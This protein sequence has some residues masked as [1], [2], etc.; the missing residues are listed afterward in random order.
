MVVDYLRY[1]YTADCQFGTDPGLTQRIQWYRCAD[2][3]VPFGFPVRFGSEVWYGHEPFEGAGERPHFPSDWVDGSFPVPVAGNT[4]FCGTKQVMQNGWPGPLPVG[5]E[6]RNTGLAV[7][8]NPGPWNSYVRHFVNS[9]LSSSQIISHDVNAYIA[10]GTIITH[11][12]NATLATGESITHNVDATL[13]TGESITHNVDATLATGESIYHHIESVL[14]ELRSIDHNVDAT[15]ATGESKTH[16]VDATLATGESKTHNVDAT[17]ATGESKTHNVDATLALGRSKTHN[18]DATLALGRSKTHNVDATL[19]LGR[20]KTH[21]VNSFVANSPNAIQFSGSAGSYAIANAAGLP[22]GNVTLTISLWVKFVAVSASVQEVFV[23]GASGAPNQIYAFTGTA[24]SNQWWIGN[25]SVNG[26]SSATTAVGT[27]YNVII[28]ISAGTLNVYVNNVA[29]ISG[30]ALG[31]SSVSL[32]NV[33]LAAAIDHLSNFANAAYQD[34]RMYNRVVSSG[35]R[36]LIFSGG[37]PNVD[38]GVTAGKVLW[39]I[40]NEGSGTVLHDGAGSNNATIN[41]GTWVT[42]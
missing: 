27:K 5:L 35:E 13:A 2:T 31:T 18:V 25:G 41:N 33:L 28:T 1:C 26:A 38:D 32:S 42:I 40:C 14:Q 4:G 23:Y 7:C 8:C 39:W 12:V 10:A 9:A 30:F 16:N 24:V 20:S 36:A 11:D 19:A 15:L 17:L 34:V 22:S 6:R 29:V 21:N 37:V 3:A